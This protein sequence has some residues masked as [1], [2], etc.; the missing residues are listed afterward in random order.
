M[1]QSTH[2]LVKTPEKTNAGR[3]E[4]PDLIASPPRDSEGELK[5]L[6]TAL[7]DY[8]KW[9]GR[10][11]NHEVTVVCENHTTKDTKGPASVLQHDQKKGVSG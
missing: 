3:T 10:L 11:A 9:A 5:D 7:N 4:Q 2:D 8:A 6:N 1:T